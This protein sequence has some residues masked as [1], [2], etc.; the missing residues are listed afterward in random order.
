MLAMRN[1]RDIPQNNRLEV[2]FG[3]LE[4]FLENRRGVRSI[5]RA[6]YS[7]HARTTLSGVSLRPSLDGSSPKYSSNTSTASSASDLVRWSLCCLF[8]LLPR[9]IFHSQV[10]KISSVSFRPE[11]EEIFFL[12]AKMIDKSTFR[13]LKLFAIREIWAYQQSSR[14]RDTI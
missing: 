2:F 1:E 10:S 8:T 12:L 3:I 14:L 11:R 5:T 6:Q 4:G 7:D 13:S 9:S